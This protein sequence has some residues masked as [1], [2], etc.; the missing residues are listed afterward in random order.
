M[1]TELISQSRRV[2]RG[3]NVAH[4][5]VRQRARPKHFIVFG[6]EDAEEQVRQ[7]RGNL[8]AVVCDVQ[9]PRGGVAGAGGGI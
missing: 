8:L 4:K 7:Y 3:I 1:Y 2:I 6:Y 9:F 5:L